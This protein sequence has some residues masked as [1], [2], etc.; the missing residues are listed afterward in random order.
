MIGETVAV[1]RRVDGLPDEMGEPTATWESEEV[2]NVLV[3][4]LSGSDVQDAAHP[5]G[6]RAEYRLAF[7]KSYTATCGPM[8]NARVAFLD[9]GMDAGDA[10]SALIVSGCPDVTRPCPTDW[11]MVVEVGR[12]YG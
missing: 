4:P 6:V 7:P 3:R 11:D 2:E 8:R 1:L 10:A 9:R 5:D 12:V